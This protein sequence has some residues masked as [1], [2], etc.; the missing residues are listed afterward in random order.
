MTGTPSPHSASI[1][2]SSVKPKVR[3]FEGCARRIAP[4][5]SLSADA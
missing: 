1:S 4:V 5:R 3:K 2:T